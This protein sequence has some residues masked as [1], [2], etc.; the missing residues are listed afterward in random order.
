MCPAGAISLKTYA[1]LHTKPRR[2]PIGK[3]V[4][5]RPAL[6]VRKGKVMR[7][8]IQNQ[9]KNLALKGYGYKRIADI[10]DLLPNT[11]KSHLHRHPPAEGASVC[12]HCV[13][14][15][16]RWDMQDMSLNTVQNLN[17]GLKSMGVKEI[18]ITGGEPL[19]NKEVFDIISYL[20]KEGY[21]IRIQSN[22]YLIDRSVAKRLKDC[23]AN[24]ILISID[25]LEDAHNAF[26]RNND[27]FKK[28]YK[29]VQICIQEGLFTRVNTV[30]NKLNASQLEELIQII[31]KLNVDQHS[32]FYLTPM[33]R[34]KKLKDIILSL[35]EW[36]NIQY[37][38]L[39]YSQKLGCNS[40]IK[41]QDVFHQGDMIYEDL[42]I[43]RNDNC[44][45]LSNG[46]VYHCVFFVNS[47]YCLGNIFKEDISKIWGKLPDLLEHI[48]SK[49]KKS[50]NLFKCGAGCPGMAY[51][52]GG[53]I[54]NCDPRCRPD[55]K[56]ISSC[57]RRYRK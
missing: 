6:P 33:G 18:H 8:Y 34:G 25:G 45:I 50:C 48:N 14:D 31:N 3:A 16:G 15:S 5:I 23:G 20:H 37:K 17:S 10:L 47:P 39:S 41:I 9:I 53:D 19:L 44:L 57:I 42:D 35:P 32:F 24:H 36:E 43:C 26:R 7:L 21:L 40:K 46:D 1:N 55:L 49:R 56:L 28:A 22:G 29:A 13:Y 2:F 51:C 52:F 54:S 30:V 4:E 38:I 12:Q 27:A 11:V